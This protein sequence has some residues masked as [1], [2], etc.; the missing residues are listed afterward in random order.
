MLRS[1]NR[2]R[3]MRLSF[4]ALL[5]FAACQPDFSFTAPEPPYVEPDPAPPDH[6][7][8]LSMG[9]APNQSDLVIG[10]Y[11]RDLSGYGFAV[12]TISGD[13]IEWAHEQ[14]DG[15]SDP[16]SGMDTGDR[17]K[18]G[19]M[20]VAPDGTVWAAYY[21]AT[22]KDLRY[23]HRLGGRKSWVTGKIDGTTGAV[24]EWA[25][26]A[27]DGE[28]KPVVAYFDGDTKTLKVA[29]YSANQ[30]NTNT[31]D[32]WDVTTAWTG[33]PWSGTDAAGLPISRDASVGTYARL[34]ISA[35]TEYI[36][37][38]DAGQQRL[39]LLEGTAGNYT[40]SFV[41]DAGVNQGQ[42]P[43]MLIDGGT[44]IIA[45][46]D[47]GNQDLIVS[48]RQTGG[49]SHDIADAGDYV[50]ADTELVIRAGKT[51]VLYFDGQNNDMKLATKNG[52]VWNTET[53]GSAESA[54]GFHNEIVRVDD[55]FWA[56]SYDFTSRV[57]FTH[58]IIDP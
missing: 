7:S 15:Y 39:G 42:W 44:L 21:D 8:W 28:G 31:D 52:N 2:G 45:Y 13:S 37:Y 17:G 11:D 32:E 4:A 38:Y 23:A 5:A 20:K 50:G 47:V 33:Q 51:T 6:G 27:L 12:G 3:S 16:N 25:S 9:L 1:Q 14:V 49:W 46:Q 35:G 24:G 48:T 29:H 30:D 18:Y 22:T 10:Y 56:A 58:K 26:L 41:T 34:M 57:L 19:S 55:G 40:Q 54:V 43:S 36:A 53:L